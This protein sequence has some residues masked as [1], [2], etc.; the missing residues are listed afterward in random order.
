MRALD[1]IERWFQAQIT[2]PHEARTRKASEKRSS[3]SE[4]IRPARHLDPAARVEIYSEM[5]Y[6]RLHDVLADEFVATRALC[7]HHEFH[8]V[9]RAYLREHPSRHYSLNP[10]GRKLPEFLA[11]PFKIARKGVL[12]DVAKLENAMSVIV[13]APA[14]PVLTPDDVARVP[15]EAWS[16]ARP[17]LVD[18]LE[19]HAF[20]YRANDIVRALRH[21]EPAPSLARRRTWT[22][23]WRK[24]WVVWR[25]NVDEAMHAVLA[26]L[27]DGRT[28][29]EAIEAGASAFHGPPEDLQ[30]RVSQSFREW[31][32]EGFFSRI[33]VD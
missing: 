28:L 8:R 16:R 23:V 25:M 9:V 3:A 14:S 24:D 6:A 30:A 19:V 5:Y 33:D 4:R 29:A 22:V 31:I 27:R 17:R 18:A 2:G 10:L 21:G 13:D 20:E 11:G 12:H 1:E 7:G 26:S 32:G 15:P